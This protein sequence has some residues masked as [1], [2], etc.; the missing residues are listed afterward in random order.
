VS[1]EEEFSVKSSSLP[2]TEYVEL[3]GIV[4]RPFD[5]PNH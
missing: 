2:V 5:I 1:G 4:G 3:F